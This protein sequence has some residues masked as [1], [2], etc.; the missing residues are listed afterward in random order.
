M[1]SDCH[2]IRVEKVVLGRAKNDPTRH[3]HLDHEEECTDDDD[4]RGVYTMGD[5]VCNNTI[6]QL[7]QQLVEK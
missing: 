1:C 7:I 3:S 5:V 6:S 2:R 4:I